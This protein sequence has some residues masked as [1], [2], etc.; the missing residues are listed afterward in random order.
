MEKIIPYKKLIRYAL[1]TSPLFGL[2]GATP[3]LV[4]EKIDY[5]RIQT[6]FLLISSITLTFWLIN[7]SLLKIYDSNNYL[8][9]KA[10]RYFLSFL[11]A[12]S[13]IV[14][15]T[16][17]LVKLKFFPQG[18]AHMPT[19]IKP[20]RF[21]MLPM[22]Q[23]TSINLI[24]LTLLETQI[25]QNEKLLIKLENNNLKL[26]N[27]E[28]RQQYLKQQLHPHFLFNSLSTLRSL[29][30]R[31]PPQAEEYLEKLS[32]ILRTSLDSNAKM[33]S[34]LKDEIELCQNYLLMQKVRF[35][36][37]L[38]YNIDID[39]AMYE[40]KRLP[41]HALQLLAENAIKHNSFTVSKPLH[42]QISGNSQNDSIIISNNLQH[43]NE[44]K[45]VS[46]IGLANL[47]ERYK[48]TGCGDIEVYKTQDTFSVKINVTADESI[49][50]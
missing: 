45:Q 40:K 6:G 43:R 20:E 41:I 5:T 39:D 33:L 35:G 14:V 38:H 1:L 37:A 50:Y 8:Q 22:I 29:I 24:I 48:L 44:P 16:S 4:V 11:L 26:L 49:D 32:A 36:E 2:F 27:L 25:L 42:I 30:K 3:A 34:T 15:V 10:S 47:S 12:A 13:V 17:I 23:A 9:K 21:V 28:A 46:G 7:I 31:N 18:L 19:G